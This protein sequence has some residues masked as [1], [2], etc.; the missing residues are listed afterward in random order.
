ML[1]TFETLP[2]GIDTITKSYRCSHE[3]LSFY[4]YSRPEISTILARVLRVSRVLSV[5]SEIMESYQREHQYYSPSESRYS[6]RS[7]SYSRYTLGNL[8]MSTDLIES[9]RREGLK[10]QYLALISLV[11]CF[12]S[13]G[14]ADGQQTTFFYQRS[15]KNRLFSL[16]PE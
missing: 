13:H 7:P 10:V 9:S 15:V 3:E 16:S 8:H 11:P 1:R 6:S 12:R 4:R 5:S 14:D 2:E